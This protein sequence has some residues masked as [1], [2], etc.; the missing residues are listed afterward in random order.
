MMGTV[1][2]NSTYCEDGR[3]C[4]AEPRGEYQ[5]QPDYVQCVSSTAKK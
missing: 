5:T 4:L 2:L 1:E 3:M